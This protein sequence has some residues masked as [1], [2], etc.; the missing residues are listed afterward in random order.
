MAQVKKTYDFKSVGNLKSKIQTMEQDTAVSL[1]IGILTPIS[2]EQD[3]AS[4]FKM[5]KSLSDQVR[6]NMKNLLSTNHGERLILT[7]YGANL[8]ELSYD[9][10]SEDII[11]EALTR[12]SAA[13][14]KFLPYVALET[15]EPSTVT[16]GDVIVNTIRV[17]YS[18]PS[19]SVNNQIVEVSIVVAN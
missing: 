14:T 7:D 18:I 11:T 19:L 10:T 12:I 9:L 3:D 8:K 15:F 1:P 17:G 13:V 16:D 5:S 2:F 4:M 6:D